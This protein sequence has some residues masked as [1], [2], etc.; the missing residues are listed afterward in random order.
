MYALVLSVFCKLT[1]FCFEVRLYYLTKKSSF[2]IIAKYCLG[3]RKILCLMF[4]PGQE[5]KKLKHKLTIHLI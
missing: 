5:A 2:F 4:C 1:M 3:S